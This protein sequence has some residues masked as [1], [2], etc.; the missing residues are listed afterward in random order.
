VLAL[1]QLFA[2]PAATLLAGKQ[3]L[4]FTYVPEQQRVETINNS[5]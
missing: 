1:L 3:Q 5:N 4:S 2:Q